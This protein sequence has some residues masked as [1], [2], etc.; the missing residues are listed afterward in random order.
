M[1]NPTEVPEVLRLKGWYEHDG[2]AMNFETYRGEMMAGS[3]GEGPSSRDW[4]LLSDLHAPGVGTNP[5]ADYYTCK[6]RYC[7]FKLVILYVP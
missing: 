5:K 2:H 7:V 1:I 6:V 3:S 4:N